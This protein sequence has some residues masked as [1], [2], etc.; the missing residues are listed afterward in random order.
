M[1]EFQI[2]QTIEEAANSYLE[3]VYGLFIGPQDLDTD[4]LHG[5]RGEAQAIKRLLNTL[6]RDLGYDPNSL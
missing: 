3:R 1:T 4:V 2:Y 5:L 6:R